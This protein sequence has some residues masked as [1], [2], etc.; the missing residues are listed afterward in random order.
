M[1]LL[2]STLACGA[3]RPFDH[4][5][6][7]AEALASAVLDGLARRDRTALERLALSEDEFRALVW[8]ELPAARPERNLPWDYVWQDLQ[9]KSRASLRRTL[10]VHGGRQYELVSVRHLGETS[11]YGAYQIRRDAEVTVRD[12]EGRTQQLRLFG[13]TLHQGGRVKLFSYVVD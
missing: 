3:P 10:A 2:I 13:S 9:Q 7:S 1:L 4:T 11:A 8:P 12:A 6:D 5:C